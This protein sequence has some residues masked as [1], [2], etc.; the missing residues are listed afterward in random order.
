MGAPGV[1]TQYTLSIAGGGKR[2]QHDVRITSP[3]V[4]FAEDWVCFDNAEFRV[5]SADNNQMVLVL[6]G[7]KAPEGTK[8]VLL[9][10]VG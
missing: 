8:C 7:G 4:L 5:S 6:A 2:Q 10:R 3:C 1:S 9:R